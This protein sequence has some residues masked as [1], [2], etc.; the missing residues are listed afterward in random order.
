M[1]KYNHAVH[2]LIRIND[3]RI[4]QLTELIESA[5]SFDLGSEYT[6]KLQGSLEEAIFQKGILSI[7][8]TKESEVEHA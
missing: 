5:K 1:E 4:N 2:T 7:W 6:T 8:H 3:E